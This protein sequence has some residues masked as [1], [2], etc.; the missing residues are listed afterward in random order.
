MYYK[1]NLYVMF[2]SQALYACV[3]GCL[4]GLAYASAENG[5]TLG[6]RDSIMIAHSFN[7]EE[8]GMFIM[9]IYVTC[10]I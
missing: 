10:K 2:M 5:Y 7:G 1:R 8:F 6:I 3:I 9:K 4:I